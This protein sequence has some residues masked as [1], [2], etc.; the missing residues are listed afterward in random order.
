M[1]NS[2]DELVVVSG[3][4]GRQPL[5]PALFSPSCSPFFEF[6]LLQNERVARSLAITH[7]FVEHMRESNGSLIQATYPSS[8]SAL[9]HGTQC[10]LPERRSTRSPHHGTLHLQKVMTA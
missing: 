7:M 4:F 1:V 2:L 6:R 9:Q 10:V 8:C 5:R 3:S